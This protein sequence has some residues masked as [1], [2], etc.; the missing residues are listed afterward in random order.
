M[1]AYNEFDLKSLIEQDSFDGYISLQASLSCTGEVVVEYKGAL[2]ISLHNS[3]LDITS[4]DNIFGLKVTKDKSRA[5][6]LDNH[7]VELGTSDWPKIIIP[8]IN[9]S[10]QKTDI[11][12][13]DR[14]V[15]SGIRDVLY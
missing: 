14:L 10:S 9:S 2:E 5:V 1:R 6:E 13:P 3:R 7:P 8:I 15:L 4:I 12:R 11:I